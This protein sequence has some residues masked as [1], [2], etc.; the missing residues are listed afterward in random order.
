MVNKKKGGLSKRYQASFET[1][2]SK[3]GSRKGVM[4]WKKY[5]TSVRSALRRIR[6]Y[7]KVIRYIVHL[8]VNSGL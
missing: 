8:V 1:K 5:Y 7:L 4:D 6:L 2:E 3:G